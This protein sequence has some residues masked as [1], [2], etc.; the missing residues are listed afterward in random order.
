[1]ALL[2]CKEALKIHPENAQ[3]KLFMKHLRN[4]DDKKEKEV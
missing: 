4:I 3:I 1:M 2:T